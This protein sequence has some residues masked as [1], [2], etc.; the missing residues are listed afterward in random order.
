[1]R[2]DAYIAKVAPFAQPILTH[3]R[4]TIHKACPDVVETIKWGVPAFDYHGPLCQF[5]AFKQHA[6]FGFWK[7]SLLDGT[8]KKAIEAMGNFGRLTSVKDLPSKAELTRI[9]KSAMKLNEEGEKVVRV[10]KHPSVTKLKSPADLTAALKKNAKAAKFFESLAPGQRGEYI[11]WITGAKQKATRA[12][13]L[14]TTVE[15]LGEGKR[16]NWKYEAR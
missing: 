2:V 14:K 11:A 10:L 7:A 8:D 13:R 12:T 6:V 4:A 1:M 15:W 3:L 9:I 5:A 16:R